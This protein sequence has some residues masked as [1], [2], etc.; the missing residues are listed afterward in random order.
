[1]EMMAGKG[2]QEEKGDKM[3]EEE[4]RWQNA[5]HRTPGRHRIDAIHTHIGTR[6]LLSHMSTPSE[7]PEDKR[8]R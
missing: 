4:K 2:K 6:H 8:K 7:G 1:M 3:N 5:N